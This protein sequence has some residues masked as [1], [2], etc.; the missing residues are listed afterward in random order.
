MNTI[1]LLSF[2]SLLFLRSVG[3]H[4]FRA[5][6]VEGVESIESCAAN[7][8]YNTVMPVPDVGYAE[9]HRRIVERLEYL[10]GA[11]RGRDVSA[12]PV[13]L[14]AA[15]TTN[16]DR[17]R[18]YRL[19]GRFPVNYD[20]P[21]QQLPCF[22]DRDGN[23]C[24]VAHLVA[25]SA[26]MDLVRQIAGTYRYA[27]VSAMKMPELDAW[28]ARSGLLREEILTIQ[29]PGFTRRSLSIEDPFAVPPSPIS[30]PAVVVDSL[31]SLP[32]TAAVPVPP[33]G[34]GIGSVELPQ[35]GIGR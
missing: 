30:V 1:V 6:K 28:I 17:L 25:Q 29:E 21:D 16:I 18:Q 27:T 2:F 10:E 14:Q 13:E 24:A 11:L 22:L 35:A 12:W 31:Q 8:A 9:Y 3:V 32:D 5:D 4:T 20:Y 33:V 19:E 26:G 23:L 34:P 7:P 15:R